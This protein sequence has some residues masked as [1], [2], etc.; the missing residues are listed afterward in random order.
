MTRN[1]GASAYNIPRGP[2]SLAA[3]IVI[4]SINPELR[5]LCRSF[6]PVDAPVW[7]VDGSNG[8]HPMRM[9][10]HVIDSAPGEMAIL[11]DEDAFIFD[12]DKLSRLVEWVA[13]NRIACAGM[14]DGGFVPIRQHNPNAFNSF[15][16]IIDLGQVRAK[17]NATECR[18]H[19]G[20]GRSMTRVWCQPDV[21]SPAVPY[22][23]ND[24]EP[25]YCFYFWL[26]AAGL[27]MDWL[28]GQTHIDG[29]STILNDKSGEAFLLH[30]WYARRFGTDPRQRE[31][32]TSA[33]LW[34]T[35]QH[36]AARVK[37]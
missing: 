2:K 6:I 14:G 18:S 3:T 28:T 13:S 15:F 21:L 12:F 5:K 1:F 9:I 26:H 35:I 30:T 20:T 22:E 4:P 16:N 8:W 34:A 24:F 37:P 19:K 25:Y 29:I 32:I 33:A 36:V 11:L 27:R 17:W 10:E 7:V 23:F 31:R